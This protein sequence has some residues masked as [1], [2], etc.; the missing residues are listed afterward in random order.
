LVSLAILAITLSLLDLESV[1]EQLRGVDIRFVL[2]ALIVSVPQIAVTAWRW[3]FTATRVGATLS[4]GTAWREYYVSRLLNQV[5][6]GGVAGDV[7]RVVRQA[8][9]ET[10]RVG[11]VAS[12]VVLERASGQIVL[13]IAVLTTIPFVGA[14][15]PTRPVAIV[16]G[17]LAAAVLLLVL[18]ARF[19]P[20]RQTR[21]GALLQRVEQDLTAAFVARGAFAYQLLGS[22]VAFVLLIVEFWLCNL[23]VD[24]SLS[25]GSAFVLVPWVLAAVSIP[26]TAGGW[27][28]REA[29]A[30]GIFGLV[31]YSPAEAVATSIVFGAVALLSSLPGAVVLL[32]P[33]GRDFE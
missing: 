30:G 20:L 3:H 28:I 33:R 5:L 25:L 4:L 29:A 6:P 32:R 26:L 12:S 16:F 10:G 21:L 19:G 22:A 31:G 13:W 15:A 2:V 7:A 8:N 24:G 14:A 11:R 1:V 27:G 9:S 23:A 18:A 17:A